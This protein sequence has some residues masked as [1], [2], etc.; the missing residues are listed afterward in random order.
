MVTLLRKLRRNL[1]SQNRFSKYIL[2][3]IGEIILVVIGILI[4]L[5]INDWNDQNKKAELEIKILKEIDTNLSFDLEEIREDIAIMDSINMASQEIITYLKNNSEPSKAFNYN[6]IKM[7]VAPHFNPNKSGYGLLSSKGFEI[8]K[9]DS[10]RI[11]ISDLYESYYPYYDQYEKERI[12]FKDN[13]IKPYFLKYF[14]WVS[15][16]E[17]YFLA[18][19]HTTNEDYQF[20]KE[21]DSFVKLI[22]AITFENSFVQLRAKTMEGKII[23]LKRQIAEVLD[24]N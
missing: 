18:S 13:N 16:E 22:H 17:K 21:D 4:A 23:N 19:M 10:L 9:N 20:I 24:T 3:A 7:K 8:I 2:Y 15:D 14:S 1:V 6:V 12:T 11:A 5:Q